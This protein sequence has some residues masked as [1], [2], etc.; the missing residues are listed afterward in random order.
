MTQNVKTRFSVKNRIADLQRQKGIFD[1][2]S[3]NSKAKNTR[4]PATSKNVH[5]THATRK[6]VHAIYTKKLRNDA[7]KPKESYAQHRLCLK[8][9]TIYIMC[10]AR[11]RSFQNCS[12]KERFT[13]RTLQR[14]V[15]TTCAMRENKINISSGPD[16]MHNER[17]VQDINTSRTL[18]DAQIEDSA[19]YQPVQ[20][21][22]ENS[23]TNRTQSDVKQRQMT[24][25][26]QQWCSV[27]SW[28]ILENSLA[29]NLLYVGPD[30][31]LWKIFSKVKRTYSAVSLRTTGPE[32]KRKQQETAYMTVYR[33]QSHQRDAVG[34]SSRMQQQ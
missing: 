2:A 21:Q 25:W 11:E 20:E 23:N 13:T 26:G 8:T 30:M 34:A 5:T 24:R 18:K 1:R 10:K 9:Y 4:R 29:S 33:C 14:S 12:P 16:S 3:Y 31:C 17:A 7:K 32:C 6:N 22:Y 27:I 15:H 19:R 28:F